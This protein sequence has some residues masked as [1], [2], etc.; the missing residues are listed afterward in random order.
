MSAG[1]EILTN[2]RRFNL[3]GD[4]A[5]MEKWWRAHNSFAP[6]PEHLTDDGFVIEVEG[7]AVAVWFMYPMGTS[8]ICYLGFPTIGF[9]CRHDLRDIVSE[10]M[11]KKA[12]QWASAKGFE[13]IY[14]SVGGQK[15]L[16]RLKA[17]GFVEAD[18]GNSHMFLGVK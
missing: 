1:K 6:K 13:V 5:T 14:I 17:F 7:E 16:D 9:K 2:I 3:Q 11:L 18:K 10:I 15:F 4:Y 12:K 8:K